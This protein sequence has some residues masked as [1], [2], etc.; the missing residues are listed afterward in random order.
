MPQ[1]NILVVPGGLGT[2][3]LLNNPDMISWLIKMSNSLD[4]LLSICT[5]SLLLAKAGL[6]KGRKAIT[7]H[8]AL[9]LLEEL[10]PDLKI[11]EG[12]RYVEDGFIVSAAGI[13]AGIDMSLYVVSRLLGKEVAQRTANYMEYDWDA[14]YTAMPDP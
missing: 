14:D 6:L 3:P 11:L 8:G 4:L 10:E 7:H 2:R 1:T 9:N 12:V 5:G 13:S